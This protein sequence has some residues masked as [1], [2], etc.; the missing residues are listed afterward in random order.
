MRNK[1]PQLEEV[2]SFKKL[3]EQEILFDAIDEI[4]ER[5]VTKAYG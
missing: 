1:Y 4:I 5:K 3:E 2:I